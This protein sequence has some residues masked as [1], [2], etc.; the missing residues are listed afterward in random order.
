D[1]VTSYIEHVIDASKN[2]YIAVT[3]LHRHI[4][5]SITPG[6]L[7]PL[8]FVAFRITPHRAH[9]IRERLLQDETSADP[10]RYR[11]SVLVD[12]VSVRARQGNSALAR[13]HRLRTRRA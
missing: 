2:S 12:Y 4:A 13:T 5:S 8:P 3:V 10:C 7:L 6:N 11:F 9:H 1:S